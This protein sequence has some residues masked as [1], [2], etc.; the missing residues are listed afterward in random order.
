MAFETTTGFLH[1][2]VIILCILCSIFDFLVTRI[3][4]FGRSGF[5]HIRIIRP[6]PAV[7]ACAVGSDRLMDELKLR[8]LVFRHN[9]AR[10]AQF[11]RVVY[12]QIVIVC[13]VRVVAHC[14]FSNRHRAVQELK[15]LTGLMAISTEVADT[16]FGK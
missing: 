1:Y 8:Q 5:E 6:M 2:S 10:Q 4:Q 13:T 15:L 3:T 9:M 14:A 12:Q 7:A 11:G 16:F